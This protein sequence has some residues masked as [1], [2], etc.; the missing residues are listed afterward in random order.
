MGRLKSVAIFEEPHSCSEN[1]AEDP[2]PCCK[3]V[4]E[5]LKVN[6]ITKATFDFKSSPDLYQIAII[7]FLVSDQGLLS[8]QNEKPKYYYSPPPLP[9]QN[10]LV[11][12][13]TFLI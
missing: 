11:L 9:D 10:L 4:S 1:G 6:E 8:V 5:Q 3:D 7:S 2:M 12:N 13:Q